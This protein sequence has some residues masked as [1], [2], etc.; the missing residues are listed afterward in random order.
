MG[1]S[2]TKLFSRLFST[3]R[4]MNIIMVGLDNAGKTV[5]LTKL[6]LG[7]TQTTVPTVGFNVETLEYKNVRFTMWDIG[8]QDKIRP[9]WR[10]YYNN[11]DGII[12]V[13]DSNDAARMDSSKEYGCC[14]RE[15]I[16]SMLSEDSLRGVP[17]LVLAN[18]QDLPQ[19]LKVR[20]V[21]ERLALPKLQG[22]EW[23]IQGAVA[24]QA[25][26]LYEGLDWLVDAVKAKAS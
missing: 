11:V 1:S 2:F 21:M 5:I 9:L 20:D 3:T 10:H 26:G 13:V 14:A 22:R 4:D 17:L 7:E 12:F 8:G 23:H 15:E 19:A 24:T 16:E 25:E 6:K 18:K